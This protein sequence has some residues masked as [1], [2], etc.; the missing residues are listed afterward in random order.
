MWDIERMWEQAREIIDEYQM[1]EMDDEQYRKEI[2]EN[3]CRQSKSYNE[4]EEG[5]KQAKDRFDPVNSSY[6]VAK[7]ENDKLD[8]E[9]A[10]IEQ[11]IL[12]CDQT[13]IEEEKREALVL[14]ELENEMKRL[15]WESDEIEQEAIKLQYRIED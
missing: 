8:Q 11:E 1:E 9:L 14:M 5:Y 3:H 2:R 10:R 4:V 6:Q 13:I 7:I 15:D 12:D